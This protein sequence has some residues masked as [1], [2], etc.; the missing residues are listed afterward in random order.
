VPRLSGFN[1]GICLT[2]DEKHGKTL[3]RVVIH[4]HNICCNRLFVFIVVLPYGIEK[5]S[6]VEKL[7]FVLLV[8]ES[9][10]VNERNLSEGQ[11]EDRKQWSL[12]VG[13]RRKAF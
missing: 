10:A 8:P 11:W 13:Q 1:P 6:V 7:T 3:V 4:K 5:V 12:G 2:T 9:K